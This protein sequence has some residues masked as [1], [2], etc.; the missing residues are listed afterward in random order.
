MRTERKVGF[1]ETDQMNVYMRDSSRKTSQRGAGARYMTVVD[2]DELIAAPKVWR[3]F[4]H[5]WAKRVA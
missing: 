2:I 3:E 1:V 5:R 4:V